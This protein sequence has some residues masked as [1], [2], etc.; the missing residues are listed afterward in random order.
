MGAVKSSSSAQLNAGR[1]FDPK[2]YCECCNCF[3]QVQDAGRGGWTWEVTPVYRRQASSWQPRSRHLGPGLQR[4][5]CQTG[6]DE[7]RGFSSD[8]R[9]SPGARWAG[10]GRTQSALH[11]S[12]REFVK[13]SGTSPSTTIPLAWTPQGSARRHGRSISSLFRWSL[14]HSLLQKLFCN[15]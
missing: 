4:F 5:P 10:A 6:N 7:F 9:T 15:R 13:G 3:E 12:S 11:L 8:H 2:G 14:V 1:Q